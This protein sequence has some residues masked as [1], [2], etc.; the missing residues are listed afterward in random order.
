MNK[1]IYVAGNNAVKLENNQTNYKKQKMSEQKMPQGK[2]I[3][4]Y[5]SVKTNIAYTIVLCFAIIATLAVIMLLLKST[6]TVADASEQV[7]QLQKELVKIKKTN[8]L[9]STDINGH[10]NMEVVFEIATTQMGMIQPSAEN[11]QYYEMTKSSYTV[12]YDQ[13][14]VPLEETEVTIGNV[15]GFIK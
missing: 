7:I 15:L 6:F 12:Q 4:A 13:I 2:E 3:P 14:N 8:E 5:P 9:L 11:V 10:V 1:T